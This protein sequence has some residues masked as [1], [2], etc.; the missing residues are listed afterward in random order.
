MSSFKSVF[1]TFGA[2][3]SISGAA[4]GQD[5]GWQISLEGLALQRTGT[6][7]VPLAIDTGTA[8]VLLSAD[9]FDTD[10]HGG[11]K[12]S[13]V[14]ET[15]EQNAFV[16]SGFYTGSMGSERILDAADAEMII[17]GATFGTSPIHF[18]YESSLLGLEANW[19][20]TL[21]NNRVNVLAGLGF[22]SLDETMVVTDAAS[23]PDLFNGDLVN[24]MIGAQVGIEATVLDEERWQVLGGGKL[25]IYANSAS[26][27][28]AFPQ[29]GPAA[30][31]DATGNSTVYSAELWV[32]AQYRLTDRV[33]LELGYQA[34]LL[35][36]V[37]LMPEQFDDLAVPILGEMDMGGRPLY[38]GITFGISSAW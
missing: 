34:L 16:L 12:F 4:F 37:G 17:Y 5:L 24:N 35:R 25:G 19:Q 32:G 29:A 28:A 14:R 30:I 18:G 20:H 22:M 27:D 6:E 33:S 2:M 13:A 10:I 38:H 9:E 15:S 21:Q 26:F 36:N 3:L 31:F 11:L 8:A 1:A 7:S 23:G